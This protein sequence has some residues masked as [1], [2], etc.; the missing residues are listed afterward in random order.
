MHRLQELVR[1]HRLGRGPRQIARE[2]GMSPNTERRYRDIFAATGLL[3]GDPAD[4]PGIEELHARVEAKMPSKSG[5]A[6]ASSVSRWRPEIE[7]LHRGGA[8]PRAIYD[9][10][11]REKRL[12]FSGSYSAVKRLCRGLSKSAGPK[13]TDVAIPIHAPP[14][15]AQVEFGYL[16]IFY[17]PA[18]GKMRK[19]WVFVLVMAQSR[20][21][22]CRIAF[23][24]TIETWIR[25][26]VEAFEELGGAPSSIVP[27]N[28][29][30]AVIQAAF[31]IDTPAA[32]NRSYREMA[33]HPGV[34]IDPTPPRSPEK[35][36]RVENAVRY[37]KHNFLPT[38]IAH[39]DAG[40]NQSMGEIESRRN[41]TK[42]AAALQTWVCETANQRTH[43]T[44]GH[45]PAAAFE[46]ERSALIELPVARFELILW[47]KAKVHRDSHVAFKRRLYSVPWRFLGKEVWIKVNAHSV[48]IF[49]EDVRIATHGRRGSGPRS[50]S[51]GHLP[52]ERAAL[53]QR[54]REYWEERVE[55][56]AP[57]VRDFIRSVF[58]Q[59]NVLSM[60]RSVQ[61]IVTHLEKFPKTRAIAACRRADYYG[62]YRYGEI[63]RIL[64]RG[65]DFHPLPIAVIVSDSDETG[66]AKTTTYRFARRLGELIQQP[67]E[68]THEPQ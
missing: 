45:R 50:T 2:L 39:A 12:D 9:W 35:K 42:L 60:L 3:V 7:E 24:Q 46:H 32:L 15:E 34:R 21:M 61:A 6:R 59:D 31:K 19:T 1:L 54:S 28:L 48:I 20:Q 63:K 17:D 36:G 52:E 40:P 11:K 64:L 22:V 65:L 47:K 27:D 55:S 5:E 44:T 16:G 26:H 14:G 4:L 25:V 41:A 68:K 37:V 13:P 30:A 8:R 66:P 29:K 10:L 62:A 51:P 49:C 58:D 56:I 57:S 38:F 53:G 43:G 23:D 18:T 67:L 33:R